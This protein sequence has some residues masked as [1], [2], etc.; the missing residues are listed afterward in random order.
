MALMKNNEEIKNITVN[1]FFTA[2]KKQKKIQEVNN[3]D[4]LSPEMQYWVVQMSES[5]VSGDWRASNTLNKS[6]TKIYTRPTLSDKNKIRKIK[7]ALVCAITIGEYDNS[8]V[9]NINCHLDINFLWNCFK[10]ELGY[11]FVPHT[12]TEEINQWTN[13]NKIPPKS[14]KCNWSQQEVIQMCTRTC[15]LFKKDSS[16]YDA[17][18]FV[19]TCHGT[20]NV[21][22]CSDGL[23]IDRL[24]IIRLITLPLSD[25]ERNLPKIFLMD[26]CRGGFQFDDVTEEKKQQIPYNTFHQ[27]KTIF[28]LTD[29]NDLI[30]KKIKHDD[31]VFIGTDYNVML[32]ETSIEGFISWTHPS[33]GSYFI[34]VLCTAMLHNIQS[35]IE[36]TFFL[37]LIRYTAQ[38]LEKYHLQIAT[39]TLYGGDINNLIFKPKHQKKKPSMLNKMWNIFGNTSDNKYENIPTPGLV[40]LAMEKPFVKPQIIIN[41]EKEAV[42]QQSKQQNINE[43]DITKLTLDHV[44]DETMLSFVQ[45]IIAK[46]QNKFP[47]LDCSKIID[48]FL[49]L[50]H[51]TNTSIPAVPGKLNELQ[52]HYKNSIIRRNDEQN[53][54]VKNPLVC[55]IPIDNNGDNNNNNDELEKLIKKCWYFFRYECKCKFVPTTDTICKLEEKTNSNECEEQFRNFNSP[56]AINDM[57]SSIPPKWKFHWTQTDIMNTLNNCAYF[58][59]NKQNELDGFI[60]LMFGNSKSIITSDNHIIQPLAITRFFAQNLTNDLRKYPKLFVFDFIQS[61]YY[62]KTNYTQLQKQKLSLILDVFMNDKKYQKQLWNTKNEQSIDQNTTILM[63]APPQYTNNM[64]KSSSSTQKTK[65]TENLINYMKYKNDNNFGNTPFLSIIYELSNQLKTQ[66]MPLPVTVI[67]GENCYRTCYTLKNNTMSLIQKDDDEY[68]KEENDDD[69]TDNYIKKLLQNYKDKMA[70]ENVFSYAENQMTYGQF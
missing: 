17:L 67:I 21:V 28:S 32:L 7:N 39:V 66:Q 24:A 26:C 40:E 19:I 63:A 18:F 68:K 31:N 64:K 65:L 37:D 50:M 11:T 42:K 51:K 47:K 44:K 15:N 14:W 45:N 12:D 2:L 69:N 9:T 20:S 3:Y 6:M 41:E 62:S 30:S 55:I 16:E 36:D 34:S 1:E 38:Q 54:N 59:S 35:G 22:V 58:L 48:Y 53:V 23:K 61:D 10:C 56:I 33:I 43:K 29:C 25:R 57:A 70:W 46:G 13:D 4:Q 52:I 49:K 8:N 5:L 27:P 60:L